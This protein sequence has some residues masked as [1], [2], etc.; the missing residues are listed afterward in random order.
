MDSVMGNNSAHPSFRE[1]SVRPSL[2][3]TDSISSDNS[4][5]AENLVDIPVSPSMMVSPLHFSCKCLIVVWIIRVD[6]Q[7]R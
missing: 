5:D 2:M 3:R 4:I 6:S 7:V 1:E